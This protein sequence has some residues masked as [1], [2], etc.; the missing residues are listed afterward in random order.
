MAVPLR[1]PA[2]LNPMP[3]PVHATD[4]ADLRRRLAMVVDS[5]ATPE[6][7]AD[8]PAESAAAH[9]S[10]PNAGE[11]AE[12]VRRELDP[13]AQQLQRAGEQSGRIVERL[14]AVEHRV[15]RI[16]SHV[17]DSL[18]LADRRLIKMRQEITIAVGLGAVSNLVLAL[19]VILG[20]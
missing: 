19:V 10:E 11:F 6:Q 16:Y 9:R 8:R 7:S 13:L 5:L 3:R 20:R 2:H 1:R 18:R 4:V 12:L 17:D 15:D 14:I